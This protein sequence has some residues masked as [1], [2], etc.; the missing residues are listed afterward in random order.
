MEYDST[1]TK[2]VGHAIL[3]I[4]KVFG[5]E[6]KIGLVNAQLN[7]V[8]FGLDGMNIAIDATGFFVNRLYG[9]LGGLA[10]PP[11]KITGQAD[12]TGGPKVLD[13]AAIEGK[14]LTLTVD[15]SGNFGGSGDLKLFSFDL[16]A[17]EFDLDKNKG[18]SIQA[19]LNAMDIVEANLT[20][21]CDK[22]LHLQGVA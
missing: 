5:I 21:K 18:F 2:F 6:G 13:V 1:E 22:S 8:G 15:M 12:I 11:L 16:A 20:L 3:E 7:E 19:T 10:Q 4:P 14:N 9:E 17:G